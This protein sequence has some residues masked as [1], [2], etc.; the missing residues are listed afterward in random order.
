MLTPPPA[1]ASPAYAMG[2]N[3]AATREP[4]HPDTS[5]SYTMGHNDYRDQ[6]PEA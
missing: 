3:D 5:A 2:W 6:H 4:L 1:G